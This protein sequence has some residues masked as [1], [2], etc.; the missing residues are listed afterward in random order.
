MTTAA[1]D[2]HYGAGVDRVARW[3]TDEHIQLAG[4]ARRF[5]AAELVPNIERWRKQGIVDR[6]FWYKAG[7]LGLLGAAIPERYGGAGG[8]YGHDLVIWLE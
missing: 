5:F 8:D 3:M 1:T 7:E 2:F 6:E 4:M